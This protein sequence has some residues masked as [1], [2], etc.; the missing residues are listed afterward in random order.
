MQ[1]IQN[2]GY[3]S[4]L[5]TTVNIKK[6]H[7]GGIKMGQKVWIVAFLLISAWLLWWT[8]NNP[9]PDGYQNEY[10]HIGNAFDLFHALQEG[11]FWH[12]RWYAYTSYWP[13]GFY[14]V[15]WP[16]LWVLGGNISTLILSNILYLFVL[17]WSM[18]RLSIRYNS[19]LSPYILLFSPAVFGSL[20]RFEPN[21]A[22]VAVTALGVLA[23]AESNYFQHRQWSLVWG[24][25]LGVGLMLDRLTVGFYLVPWLLAVWMHAPFRLDRLAKKNFFYASALCFALTIAYYREFVL[26]HSAEL[27]SQAPVGEIDSVGTLVLSDNP[28]P[29]LYYLVSLLDTQAGFVIGCTMLVG[30]GYSLRQSKMDNTLLWW[31]LLPGLVFFSMLAKKQVYYTF[32]ILVPLAIVAGRVPVLSWISVIAGVFL[33]LQQGCGVFPLAGVWSSFDRVSDSVLVKTLPPSIVEPRYLLSKPPSHTAYSVQPIID[34]LVDKRYDMSPEEVVVFSEDQTWFEGFVVL[35]LREY[36]DGHIRGIT[37]DPIGVWEFHTQSR[38]L[39]WITDSTSSWP[40]AESIERELQADHY[41]LTELPAISTAIVGMQPEF[42]PL[43]SW[44][45]EDTKLWLFVRK[46]M[47]KQP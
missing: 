17:L 33:W 16:F 11:D 41:I 30:V 42:V 10:L 22:N 2:I 46:D 28:L 43:G 35:Q 36:W 25:T 18:H 26:R 39:V 44:E 15:P 5:P 13:W 20:I 29:I 31:V 3:N 21:F 24:A 40:T 27:L 38:Y 4:L 37:Q 1:F 14:A 12:V 7:I 47:P 8:S 6:T 32:P 34:L 9:L 23:M 45:I 19:P